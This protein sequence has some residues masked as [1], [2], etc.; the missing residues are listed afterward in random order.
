MK[1]GSPA[2]AQYV[3]SPSRSPA[4]VAEVLSARLA[5]P[6]WRFHASV[7]VQSLLAFAVRQPVICT[8]QP[9]CARSTPSEE[10]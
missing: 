3:S 2:A 8:F 1:S 10:R 4:R 9:S 6:A 7:A 5:T